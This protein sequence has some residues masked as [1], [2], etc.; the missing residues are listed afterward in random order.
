[1]RDRRAAWTQIRDGAAV[2]RL[3]FRNARND[4]SSPRNEGMNAQREDYTAS[5]MRSNRP[6]STWLWPAIAAIAL[7]A[8][9]SPRAAAITP[10]E[11][12]AADSAA[13][14]ADSLAATTPPTMGPW[15]EGDIGLW[16]GQRAM[17]GSGT[18]RDHAL[19]F[20]FVGSARPASWPLA[21]DLA[22]HV[23]LNRDLTRQPNGT[24]TP[25]EHGSNVTEIHLGAGHDIPL[26]GRLHG[27]LAGGLALISASF[28][29]DAP[30]SDH[31]S[32]R[33]GY[34]R[35]ALLAR[36]G[37]VE[38]GLNASWVVT[39]SQRLVA[40]A[41]RASG[42][43][44]G[45][46]A[47]VGGRM[48]GTPP[49]TKMTPWRRGFELREAFVAE[50]AG[51]SRD[52]FVSA[53]PLDVRFVGYRRRPAFDGS[54]TL[55]REPA[56]EWAAMFGVSYLHQEMDF[57][58]A[59]VFGP[60]DIPLGRATM[61]AVR[62]WMDGVHDLQHGA[63]SSHLLR[64]RVGVSL[65]ISWPSAIRGAPNLDPSLTIDRITGHTQLL[66]SF[67]SAIEMRVPG[68]L[69]WL[70][71]WYEPTAGFGPPP[72]EMTTAGSS[73]YR[74]GYAGFAPQMLGASIGW[75]R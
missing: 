18:P 60:E 15:D 2:L 68:T 20:G 47:G 42:P 16:F 38:G 13:D 3:G 43:A 6:A 56:G 12:A 28:A 21:L 59:S 55:G 14:R 51:S 50:N 53:T 8:L 34:V 32:Y 9:G 44:F 66:A 70:G 30:G 11:V 72:I 24:Y 35:A 75:H 7:L 57:G 26:A 27:Y 49:A 41:R 54:V 65:G 39:S 10:R 19:Q 52:E 22:L 48:R 23:Y 64:G 31:L 63:R 62:V 33:G 5:A 29:S 36:W 73:T 58:L 45:V 17:T 61:H 67:R 40:D 1:V 69:A 37:I 46:I 71:A 4:A 25:P 74:T